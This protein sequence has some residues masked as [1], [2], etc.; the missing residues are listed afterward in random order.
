MDSAKDIARE[1]VISL[2]SY[3]KNGD[4]VRSPVWLVEDRGVI[5]VRTD[6]T[7]W[8]AKRIRRNPR[9]RVAPSDMRGKVTGAWSDGEAH[10][11]EGDV[12]EQAIRLIKK[13]YG[14]MGALVDSFNSVRGRHQVAVIAIKLA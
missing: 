7:S 8:K 13:K 6:P 5:Y 3:R 14:M 2:E 12:A 4:A 11:V 9:V 10:F 1:R